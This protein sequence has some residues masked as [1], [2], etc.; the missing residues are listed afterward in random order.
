MRL[1]LSKARDTVET[2]TPQSRA[3]SFSV[4]MME[5]TF[6]SICFKV[7]VLGACW[8][9]INVLHKNAKRFLV[10]A[11]KRGILTKKA[12]N[13]IL[14]SENDCTNAAIRLISVRILYHNSSECQYCVKSNRFIFT[15]LCKRLH[16]RCT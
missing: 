9:K 1:D 2:E 10:I 5:H 16:K 11:K 13:C 8:I 12:E 7:Y 3:T 14:F 4:T 6:Q 15:H